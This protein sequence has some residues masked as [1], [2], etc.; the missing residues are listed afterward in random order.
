M[1]R[2]KT[3]IVLSPQHKEWLQNQGSLS[4]VISQLLED[5][6]LRRAA[7]ARE[8]AAELAQM[9]PQE[10]YLYWLAECFH[11]RR[12]MKK[13]EVSESDVL[14]WQDSNP[15][16]SARALAAQQSFLDDLE[17]LIVDAARGVRHIDKGAMTGLLAFLSNHAP[18]WGR[19]K[20]ELLSRVFG[21]VVEELLKIV[22]KRINPSTYQEIADEFASYRDLKFSE[23][24]E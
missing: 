14:G 5:E 23:F 13:A 11:T 16:Y 18:N 6:I 15:G 4:D 22:Q 21:P 3:S 17:L 1:A 7:E 19:V 8:E 24:S 12:A 2:T 9:S 20:A 10:R